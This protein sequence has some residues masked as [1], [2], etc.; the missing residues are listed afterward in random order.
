MIQK[1]FQE[2]FLTILIFS[3]ISANAAY[4]IEVQD[5]SGNILELK[6]HRSTSTNTLY[7]E[8]QM[9]MKKNQPFFLL[10]NHKII[11]QSDRISIRRTIPIRCIKFVCI[12]I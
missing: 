3:I 6:L 12:E 2:T 10:H 1:G 5:L 7:E 11:E 9:K 8:V 4:Q